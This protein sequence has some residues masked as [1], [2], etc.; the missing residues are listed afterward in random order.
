MASA[1]VTKSTVRQSIVWL[2]VYYDLHSFFTTPRFGFRLC[3]KERCIL[4]V[5][6]FLSIRLNNV[7]TEKRFN[8][9]P[10]L[11]VHKMFEKLSLTQEIG[12]TFDCIRDLSKGRCAI[13]KG[14]GWGEIPY[15]CPFPPA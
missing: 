1:I 10:H 12:V 3:I 6:S 5:T 13:R 15:S 11:D 9:G 7:M 8:G 14:G 2:D 4:G